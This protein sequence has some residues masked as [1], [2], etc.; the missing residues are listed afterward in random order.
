MNVEVVVLSSVKHE[1]VMSVVDMSQPM[2][3]PFPI[4]TSRNRTQA[5]HAHSAERNVV[6]RCMIIVLKALQ[7]CSVKCHDFS[8]DRSVAVLLIYVVR[9]QVVRY[10]NLETSLEN[11]R[12][13]VICW[14]DLL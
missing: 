7:I 13:N 2:Y 1:C 6:Y 9:V 12:L 5:C 4:H 14:S 3:H 8:I 10:M 11:H